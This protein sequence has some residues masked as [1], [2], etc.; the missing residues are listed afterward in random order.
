[1]RELPPLVVTCRQWL[2]HRA[3]VDASAT[4]CGCSCLHQQHTRNGFA[5]ESTL[6]DVIARS[7]APA[8]DE[9]LQLQARTA[10]PSKPANRVMRSAA[11]TNRI[12]DSR[13]FRDVFAQAVAMFEDLL[14]TT[15][16]AALADSK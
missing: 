10:S 16:N 4:P 13:S 1:M 7:R 3:F 11:N 8:R 6:L 14:I 5:S 15:V 9:L 12:T 2:R